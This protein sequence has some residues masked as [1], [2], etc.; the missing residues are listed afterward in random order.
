VTN[1]PSKQFSEGIRQQLRGDLAATAGK[2][3]DKELATL[4][5]ELEGLG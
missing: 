1:R 3:L 4:R 2:T 5:T